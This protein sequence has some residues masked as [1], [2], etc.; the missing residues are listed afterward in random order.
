MLENS[1]R[2]IGKKGKKMA[3]QKGT[4]ETAKVAGGET[5]TDEKNTSKKKYIADENSKG[6]IS[7]YIGES[8]MLHLEHGF[9]WC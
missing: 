3:C 2:C 1:G 8:K 5:T 4:L 9:V 6:N 7:E